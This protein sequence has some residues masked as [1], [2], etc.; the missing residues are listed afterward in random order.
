[1]LEDI[2]PPGDA[3]L[4]RLT[5]YVQHKFELEEKIASGLG[6]PHDLDEL[7]KTGAEYYPLAAQ[8]D[9][10]P[11]IQDRSIEFTAAKSGGIIG[12]VNFCT[13]QAKRALVEAHFQEA[14]M[15]NP[16]FASVFLDAARNWNNLAAN[17][18]PS[19]PSEM[20]SEILSD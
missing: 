1:M 3:D 9:S 15:V 13:D 12:R 20:I 2:Q 17:Y 18:R 19:N 6:T 11:E 4:E 8:R 10:D 16:D 7:I 14:E 5:E